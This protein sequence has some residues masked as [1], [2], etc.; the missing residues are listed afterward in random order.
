MIH[1]LSLRKFGIHE[2]TDV[3]FDDGVNLFVGPNGSGKSMLGDALFWCLYGESLRDGRKWKPDDGASVEAV[4]G[5][6]T[7]IRRLKHGKT[8]LSL[9]GLETGRITEIQEEINRRFGEA[10]YNKAVRFF[11]RSKAA[12]FSLATDGERKRIVESLI[13]VEVF[14]IVFDKYKEEKKV[15]L[16]GQREYELKCSE[17][18]ERMAYLQ[19]GVASLVEPEK[20][21]QALVDLIKGVYLGLAEAEII[22]INDELKSME[23]SAKDPVVPDGIDDLKDTINHARESLHDYDK[24]EAI[25]HKEF[26]RLQALGTGKCSYCGNFTGLTN[27]DLAC[28]RHAWDNLYSLRDQQKAKVLELEQKMSDLRHVYAEAAIEWKNKKSQYDSVLLDLRVKLNNAENKRNRCLSKIAEHEIALADYESEVRE[29]EK[30]KAE[31]LGEL[32]KLNNEW[33]GHRLTLKAYECRLRQ[34]E[35]LLTVF[36]YKGARVIA[37]SEAF[38]VVAQVATEVVQRVGYDERH[39]HARLSLDVSQDLSKVELGVSLG[40]YQG[41]YG[42]LSEGEGALF[43]FALLKALGALP[44]RKGSVLPLLYDDV[45]EALDVNHKQGVCAYLEAEAENDQVI[46]FTHDESA[47]GMFNDVRVFNVEEGEVSE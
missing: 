31:I 46:L 24:Q 40:N 26:M 43:D 4:V 27:D 22:K 6:S 1:S 11:H 25:L 41:G 45:L 7:V 16:S 36:G 38:Q 34:V 15:L 39:K 5:D 47:I 14:D 13:G 23:F 32:S 3:E 19:G 2:K 10:W 17:L 42:G 37:L 8:V 33:W 30:R 9:D 21:D 28:A 18:R 44:W 29:Y 12:R 35:D 20:P